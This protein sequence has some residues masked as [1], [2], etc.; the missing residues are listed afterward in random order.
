MSLFTKE[1]IGSFI[2]TALEGGSNYWIDH[3]AV[4]RDNWLEGAKYYDIP[5]KGG[6]IIITEY[7]GDGAE[8][9]LNKEGIAEGLEILR[10]K[11]PW[12]FRD[13]VRETYDA[14]AADAFLQCAVLGD[15]VYG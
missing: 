14:A 4:P 10:I 9:V 7:D 15:I 2:V 12:H 11:Y 8:K 6:A 1:E 3:V 5:M 13:L